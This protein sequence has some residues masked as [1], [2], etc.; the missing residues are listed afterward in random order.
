MLKIDRNLFDIG[1]MDALAM[2]DTPLHRLEPRAK[3]ITTLVFIV[4][5]IPFGRVE[6]KVMQ[7]LETACVSHLCKRPPY[8]L[9]GGEKRAVA[10]AS[11]LSIGEENECMNSENGHRTPHLTFSLPGKD[12]FAKTNLHN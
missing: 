1:R 5:D 11:V 2:G 8:K 6:I 12:S 10:I 4:A 9:S 7:A 3:L